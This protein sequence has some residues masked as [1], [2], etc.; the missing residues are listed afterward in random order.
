MQVA[1]D[2]GGARGFPVGQRI[3]SHCTTRSGVTAFREP[4]LG[5]NV[6]P[7]HPPREGD[8]DTDMAT[9]VLS[10]PLSSRSFWAAAPRASP[11]QE[12]LPRRTSPLPQA[13]PRR[14]PTFSQLLKRY[15]DLLL[16]QRLLLLRRRLGTRPRSA[17]LLDC[18]P[19]P[20]SCLEPAFVRA[21]GSI[22]TPV[23]QPPRAPTSLRTGFAHVGEGGG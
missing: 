16:L 1:Q 6:Y 4:R 5:H 9:P 21:E 18:T 17:T 8:G 20:S 3:G 10:S 19:K 15:C 14:K 22:L 2:L 23:L 12:S 13:L 7:A 11:E